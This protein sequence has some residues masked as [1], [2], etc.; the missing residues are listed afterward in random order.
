VRSWIVKCIVLAT[1]A[2]LLTVAAPAEAQEPIVVG[3]GGQLLR[4]ASTTF[5]GFGGDAAKSIKPLGSKASLSLVGDI[6]WVGAKGYRI[7]LFQGGTRVSVRYSTKVK[8]FGQ[9]LVGATRSTYPG[10]SEVNLVFTVGGGVDVPFSETVG[11]RAQFDFPTVKFD[12]GSDKQRRAFVG[13]SFLIGG[14]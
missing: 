5:R 9:F 11:I 6:T 4:D 10:F 12:G 8:P 7:A 2:F 14:S 3:A 1:A 13:L